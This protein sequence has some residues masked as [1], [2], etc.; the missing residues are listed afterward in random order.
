MSE[1]KSLFSLEKFVKMLHKQLTSICITN[2]SC[3][4]S[5]SNYSNL[6]C[7]ILMRILRYYT[8]KMYCQ[9]ICQA[10]IPA[11]Q[12][13][14][15]KQKSPSE[16]YDDLVFVNFLVF[17]SSIDNWNVKKVLIFIFSF[18]GLCPQHISSTA[19]N[20]TRRAPKNRCFLVKN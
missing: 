1:E 5:S 14:I 8:I 6:Y 16:S 11:C 15:K 10:Y 13:V 12:L 9:W 3:Y 4:C 17:N 7:N 19:A 18:W 2:V 20:K